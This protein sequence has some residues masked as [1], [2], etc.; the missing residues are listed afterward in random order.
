MEVKR[1]LQPYKL[2]AA[3]N[4]TAK[5]ELSQTGFLASYTTAT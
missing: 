3:A 1:N 5:S 4:A 2:K